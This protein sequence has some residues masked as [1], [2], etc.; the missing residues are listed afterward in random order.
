[1]E[2][3]YYVKSVSIKKDSTWK[4]YSYSVYYYHE[5]NPNF[6]Y[7]ESWSSEDFK[8]LYWDIDLNS[9]VWQR[10]GVKKELI[11]K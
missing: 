4:P 6:I 5:K 9:L 10:I 11:L 8:K 2:K 1:M 3:N 7:G